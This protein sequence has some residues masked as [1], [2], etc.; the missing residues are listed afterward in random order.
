M[1]LAEVVFIS[2]E[3]AHRLY[4]TLKGEHREISGHS[5]RAETRSTWGALSQTRE[6]LRA[7]GPLSMCS[8]CLYPCMKTK[9][10]SFIG[11]EPVQLEVHVTGSI[12]TTQ[13]R[14]Q[15]R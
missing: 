3:V 5:H 2:G 13:G 6:V 15:K 14:R 4:K 8:D 11:M 10:L 12:K 9:A 7:L 1:M